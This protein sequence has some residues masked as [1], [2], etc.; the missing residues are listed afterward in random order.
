M[1]Y[2]PENTAAGWLFYSARKLLRTRTVIVLRIQLVWM[3]FDFMTFVM[4]FV[5]E[6]WANQV[7]QFPRTL[8]II[9]AI[10]ITPM[11]QA[12][13]GVNSPNSSGNSQPF[14]GTSYE[15]EPG[16]Y[17]DSIGILT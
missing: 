1:S 17:T 11:V 3:A 5:L 16:L 7:K 6:N 14:S 13:I 4:T 9:S 10:E 12:D 15:A 2:Y 8:P